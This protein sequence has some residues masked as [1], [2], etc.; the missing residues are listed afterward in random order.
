[1]T[2]EGEKGE[3]EKRKKQDTA[4]RAFEA[5]RKTRSR[6]RC[7]L[8]LSAAFSSVMSLAHREPMPLLTELFTVALSRICYE[9]RSNGC[10]WGQNGAFFSSY[11]GAGTRPFSPRAWRWCPRCEVLTA[12][13]ARSGAVSRLQAGLTPQHPTGSRWWPVSPGPPSSPAGLGSLPE[14]PF[15]WQHREGVGLA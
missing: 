2:S 14:S 12:G 1:M 6:S 9:L 8:H 11:R 15:T 5:T 13:D 4:H 3:K 10:R 7:S